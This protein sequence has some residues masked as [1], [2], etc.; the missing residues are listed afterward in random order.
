MRSLTSIL[1][2]FLLVG[3]I[4]PTVLTVNVAPADASAAAAMLEAGTG[5]IRGS[6]L[7]RQRG[8][9]V[10]TCAGNDVFL[11]PGT[12]SASSELRR[13]FGGDQ[14]Y[15]RNGAD[16]LGG[17]KLVAAPDPHRQ[18]MCDAQGFFTFANLKPGKWYVMT[19]I[20]WVVSDNTQGGTLLTSTDLAEG[21]S[22][23]V[24]LTVR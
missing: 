7:L 8:G 4:P 22:V 17:G 23:E 15:V 21:A 10:V 9:G 18:A 1:T 19:A 5:T 11:I 20:T 3:C 6:G 24:V 16:A 12:P 13:L 14:G 2:A